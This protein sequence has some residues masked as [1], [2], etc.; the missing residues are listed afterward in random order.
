MDGWMDGWD[1]LFF[2]LFIMGMR[3]FMGVYIGVHVAERVVYCYFN[4]AV[5]CV[6]CRSKL[7]KGF[8]LL[9]VLQLDTG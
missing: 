6:Q 8:P 9:G 1:W 3:D 2:T 7:L 4:C 5:W